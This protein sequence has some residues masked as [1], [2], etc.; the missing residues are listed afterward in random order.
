VIAWTTCVITSCG[1]RARIKAMI[2]NLM[3][4]DAAA[5]FMTF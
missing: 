4:S 2:E 1:I 3:K 5:Y